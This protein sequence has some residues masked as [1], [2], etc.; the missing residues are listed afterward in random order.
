MSSAPPQSL[1]ADALELLRAERDR[2]RIENEGLRARVAK[3]EERIA[4]IQEI[5]ALL[6]HAVRFDELLE[7]LVDRIRRIM[8]AERAALFLFDE[9]R[10]TLWSRVV[11]GERTREIR[12]R[13]GEGIAGWVAMNGTSVNVKDAYRDA[14]FVTRYDEETGFRTTSVLC[15]PMRDK[16]GRIVGVVQV[17]NRRLGWF[18]VDDE[19]LLSAISNTAAVVLE[20]QQMYLAEIDRNLELRE[21]RGALEQQVQRLD[22]LYELQEAV[23]QVDEPEHV[24][25]A[26]ARGAVQAVP[27][28]G[29]CVTLYDGEQVSEFTWVR[30]AD[31]DFEP[32]ERDWD[33]TLRDE[34]VTSGMALV[35]NTMSCMPM[36]VAPPIADLDAPV[37]S[38]LDVQSVCIAPLVVGGRT[39]GAIELINRRGVDA[40]GR[41]SFSDEDRKVLMLIAAKISSVV[42][43]MLARRRE[44][45][46]D[47]LSAIGRMLSGVVHD[48]KTPLTIAS[49]YVQLMERIDD[50]DKRRLWSKKVGAQFDH[51]DGMMREVL[52]YARGETELLMRTIH[53]HAFVE[54][55]EEWLKPELV[56]RGI[57]LEIEGRYRGDARF[58]EGKIKR[59]LFNLARNAREAMGDT[60]HYRIVFDRV[61]DE[62][63]IRCTDDGPGIPEAIRG[64]LF[65]VFV[66]TR[67][68]GNS[69]LGLAIVRKLM[70]EHGGEVDFETEVGVGTTFV[71]RL[72]LRLDECSQLGVRPSEDGR[73][74][75]PDAVAT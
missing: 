2:L 37:A 75:A 35:C 5:G 72:P 26:I 47:R 18:T 68:G 28:R 33:P 62:L 51:L 34:V 24:V 11:T 40:D 42:G 54:D 21:A 74:P 36:A 9:D 15:Q 29:C 17:L 39:I 52:A 53:M 65:D 30:N 12:L 10:D 27:S 73:E 4:L 13:V 43:R 67:K 57:T 48:I 66:S 6:G 60:G 38:A 63:V 58:D 22:T 49:G 19:A 56:D 32:A 50:P 71:L 41:R 55:L 61:G 64:S 45:V 8:D 23:S 70:T 44:R 1:E 16:S 7:R 14:R 3:S 20:N 59:V 69:G 25:E 46:Q 31:G